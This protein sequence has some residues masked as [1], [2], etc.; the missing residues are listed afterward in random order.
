[1][2]KSEHFFAALHVL[3]EVLPYQKQL[4][5]ETRGA[6]WEL[7]PPEAK[8]DLTPAD[9]QWAVSQRLI[10]PNPPREMAVSFV[11]LHYLYPRRDGWP[12]FDAGP[13]RL[14]LRAAV[15]DE[16]KVFR[17]EHLAPIRS[18]TEVINRTA[19]D[20]ATLSAR[21]QEALAIGAALHESTP[22][23]SGGEGPDGPIPPIWSE[24][25][26]QGGGGRG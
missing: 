11:F 10:D 21:T 4:S 2:I 25:N 22:I 9:L 24:P 18:L 8:R 5:P 1:M 20:A 12:A 26:W 14:D 16:R 3:S 13:R 23:H 15:R 19:T 17:A 7:F 6:L